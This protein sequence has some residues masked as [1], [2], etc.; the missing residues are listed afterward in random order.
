VNGPRSPTHTLNDDVLL[1]LFYIYR[2]DV[3]DDDENENLNFTFLGLSNGHGG[4]TKLTHD[5]RLLAGLLPLPFTIYYPYER[6]GMSTEYDGRSYTTRYSP[7]VG[8]I[9]VTFFTL[10]SYPRRC[11]PP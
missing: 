2:L 7:F 5:C 3:L 1:N 4:G 10:R 11:S 9:W 8:K 6:R